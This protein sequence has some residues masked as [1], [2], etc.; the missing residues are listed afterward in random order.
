MLQDESA[1]NTPD[2]RFGSIQNDVS[3]RS[4][5]AELRQNYAPNRRIL[6]VQAPQFLFETVNVDV[7]RNRGNYAYPPTGLQWIVSALS[8]RDLAMEIC[9][10]NLLLLRRIIE[11]PDYDP[12]RWLELL[13]MQIESFQPAI[14]GVTCLS[15]YTDLYNSGHPLVGIL[16]HVMD[17]GNIIVA[18][19]GPTS[20][21]EIRGILERGLCHFV[22]EGEG[23][24][25]V[26]RLVDVIYDQSSSHPAVQGIHFRFRG[27]LCQ[28]AGSRSEVQVKGNLV[29][30]YRHVAVEEYPKTGCLNP[31]SRM[32]GQDTPYGV[33]QLNRGCRCNCA[34]CGVRAFMGKGVRTY[35]VQSAL[36]EVR[37]LVEK[38]NVRHFEALDDDLLADP[39]AA[40]AFFKG[41]VL[42][43]ERY[44]ITWAANNGLIAMSMT[45]KLLNLMRD[46]GCIGFK[47]GIESGDISMLRRIRKPGTPD[48]F[49]RAALLLKDYQEFFVG[50]N[51]IIGLFGEETFGQMLSTFQLSVELNLDWLSFSVFQVTSRQNS[52]KENLKTDSGAIDFIPTKNSANR[53]LDEDYSLPLGASLFELPPDTVP[54]N[55]L[56]KNIWLTFNLAGNYIGNKNL[57]PGG[58]AGK[59]V[60]WVNAL[61]NS[62]PDNPYMALF[63]GL[64]QVIEG[65]LPQ[66][67]ADY[68][69]CAGILA[70]SESWRYR[71]AAFNLA[72]LMQNLPIDRDAVYKSINN[73]CTHYA[74]LQA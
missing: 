18:A 5:A 68:E 7:I 74:A 3:F 4:Y 66:A 64:G 40:E 69:K 59:F 21:N 49:R 27:E 14:V 10:L 24:D 30:S 41:L 71:F 12:G 29:E 48:A 47:V 2:E 8:G 70:H 65:N 73:I 13:D 23:E 39:T 35:R 33:F 72:D 16:R 20:T 11:D 45:R 51:Y 60:R 50:G 28:S 54:S 57:I 43:R 17:K 19:G 63:A 42:L 61:R 1:M 25:K 38:R 67:L 56:L 44:G 58:D 31:Y 15:V 53:E 62:Y 26:N 46:S 52:E 32:V 37:Y 55:A 22:I 36:E 6:F 9:D 34:F